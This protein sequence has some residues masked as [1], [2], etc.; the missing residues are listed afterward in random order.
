MSSAEETV[1]TKTVLAASVH[2]DEVSASKVIA[3]VLDL[4]IPWDSETRM[5]REHARYD[6]SFLFLVY[7]EVPEQVSV[8][9]KSEK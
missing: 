7:W 4:R 5:T 6:T 1:G 9:C 8:H 3:S 2:R